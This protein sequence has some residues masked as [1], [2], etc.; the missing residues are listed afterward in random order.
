MARVRLLHR[1]HSQ[2]SNRVNAQRFQLLPGDYNLFTGYHATSAPSAGGS[3]RRAFRA[4][5][6]TRELELSIT[7]RVHYAESVS[8]STRTWIELQ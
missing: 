4:K 5:P 7:E 1:V 3:H 2:S 8:I 6:P